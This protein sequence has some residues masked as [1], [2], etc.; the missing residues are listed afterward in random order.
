M[1]EME[2]T[3]T[4]QTDG[5]DSAAASRDRGHHGGSRI[6]N[7]LLLR[8]RLARARA[9]AADR[10]TAEQ[11][12]HLRRAKVALELGLLARNPG[13][14]VRSGSTFSQSAN[15][16]RQS[17]YWALLAQLS[18]RQ[19]PP[20]AEIWARSEPALLSTLVPRESERARVGAA[21]GS[22]FLEFDAAPAEEQRAMA[23][24]LRG[25]A[26]RAVARAHRPLR[27]LEWL[28]FVRLVRIIGLLVVLVVPLAL[29]VA[30][31]ARKPDLAQGKSWRVSSVLFEC[32]PKKSECGG[33]T[34][35]ILFH[36]KQESNPWFEYDFGE[37]LSFSSLAVVNRSDYGPEK[38]IP[39]VLEVSDDDQQFREIA[40]RTEPFWVWKPH[41]PTQH[42][43]YLRLRVARDSILHLEAIRVYR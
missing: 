37:P 30:W 9:E 20:P 22:T 32:H 39:L 40:R 17:L 41:F 3:T 34:T 8:E 19:H 23:E 35:D 29:G 26:T 2:V 10:L 42:A 31:A 36:T 11:R 28:K 6:L 33:N 5:V 21:L 24:R 16:F 4:A 13:N 14:A 7:W 1:S 18:D 15:L 25:A 43:R 38:A 12:E 27:Q